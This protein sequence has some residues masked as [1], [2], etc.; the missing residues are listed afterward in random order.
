MLT[1]AKEARN[2]CVAVAI[3]GFNPYGM[4]AAPY[5]CWPVFVIPLNLP[6]PGVL[7]Q[8]KN[9]FLSLIIP[10]HP[11][12]KMGVYMVPMW[13]ELIKAWKEGHWT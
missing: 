4:M 1:E 13:D 2:V 7:F 3:D 11:G 5:S 6:P 8:C 12:N 10:G 9:I